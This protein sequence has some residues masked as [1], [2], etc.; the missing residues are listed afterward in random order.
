MGDDIVIADEAVAKVY[1]QIMTD[2]GVDINL[3]KSL[4]S[5]VGVFEFAKRLVSPKL[6]FTP[7]GAANVL[8][9]TYSFKMIPSLFLDRVGKG[10]ELTCQQVREIF[11]NKF[12]VRASRTGSL[13]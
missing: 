6:E 2:L 5:K 9:A 3:F 4:Y 12:P 10:E 8:W 13:V 11:S 1:L 7:V